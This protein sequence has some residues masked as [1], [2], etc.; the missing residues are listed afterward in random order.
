MVCFVHWTVASARFR[1]L[2]YCVNGWIN[3]QSGYLQKRKLRPWFHN[4]SRFNLLTMVCMQNSILW[5]SGFLYE[6]VQS[7]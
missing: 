1:T 2:K 5:I 6:T 4:T 7:R 3:I